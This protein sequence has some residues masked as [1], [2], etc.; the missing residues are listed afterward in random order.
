MDAFK[1]IQDLELHEKLAIL[2]DHPKTSQEMHEEL[3]IVIQ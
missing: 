2:R 3:N 1:L